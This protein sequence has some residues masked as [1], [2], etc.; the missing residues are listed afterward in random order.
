MKRSRA[1]NK[2][3]FSLP[4]SGISCYFESMDDLSKDYKRQHSRSRR[5]FL[6]GG[7]SGGGCDMGSINTLSSG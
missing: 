7:G 4:V 3:F 6:S 2:V 5:L 1:E